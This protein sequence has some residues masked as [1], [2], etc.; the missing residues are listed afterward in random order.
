MLILGAAYLLLP[1]LVLAGLA[2]L[3]WRWREE[4]GRVLALGVT[5]T[6]AFLLLDA[7]LA[8]ALPELHLSWGPVLLTVLLASLG[9]VPPLLVLAGA[10]LLHRAG[11]R[12]LLSLWVIQGL[13]FGVEAWLFVV[14]PFRLTFTEVAVEHPAVTA[15]IRIAHLTDL[16]VERITWRER[17]ILRWLEAEEPD[18]VVLTGDYLNFAFRDDAEASAEARAWVSELHA[19]Y[20]VYAVSGNVD[21]R[22]SM[23][24]LFG[25]TGVR[26]LDDEVLRVDSPGGEIVLAGIHDDWDIVRQ[27]R[28]LA[29]MD[30]PEDRFSLL[31]F[32][33]PDLTPEAVDAG[34]DLLLAGHTHGGQVRVPGYGA[35]ITASIYGKR[36]EGGVY[37]EGPLTLVV[38]RGIGLEGLPF[39][40]RIRAFC[41][42]E[43]VMVTVGPTEPG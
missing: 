2:W 26:V 32:H 5:V 43:V 17:R 9:R 3:S 6:A 18:L 14:E 31:L 12:V 7:G 29:G 24:A 11:P 30:L 10:R 21:D 20:G 34:V 37:H 8:A 39:T 1:T 33:K 36:W 13:M 28:V 38:S 16:H 27:R 15:P 19:P 22:A 4:P 41:P 42:P 23:A 35:I 25:G 40:P